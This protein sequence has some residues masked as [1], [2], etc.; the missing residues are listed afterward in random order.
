MGRPLNPFRIG[1]FV[2]SCGLLGLIAV[3]WLGASHLF[4]DTRVYVTYFAESVKGLQK[5]AIVNYR[6]VAVGRVVSIGLGP[7]GRLIEV[8]M[9]LRPDFPIDESLAIRLREQGITGLRFLEIDTAPANTHEV[10][11]K[12][13]FQPPHPV[14]RSYPSEIQ[15]LKMALES[16][17]GKILAVDVEGL[18]E[19]WKQVG[20]AVSHVA[21]GEDLSETLKNIRRGTEALARLGQNLEIVLPREELETLKT[22]VRRGVEDFSK[23]ASY[24]EKATASQDLQTSLKNLDEGLASA[25]QAARTIAA[26]FQETHVAMTQWKD[27]TQ[28]SLILLNQN[29]YALKNLLE[30][31]TATVRALREEPQKILFPGRLQDPLEK[32]KP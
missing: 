18:L 11:P 15:E 16:L 6:G 10:T 17:Y 7:D 1:L 19:Q 23:T 32:Q 8:V 21:R 2:L 3:L 28:E 5:D 14:I 31:L 29:L 26:L 13:D 20:A 4:E 27:Q 12:L 25:T 22:H 24:L 9:H 30:Q